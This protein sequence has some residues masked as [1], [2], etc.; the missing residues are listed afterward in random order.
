[1]MKLSTPQEIEVWYTLP[2]LRR[3]FVKVLIEEHELNQKEAAKKLGLTESAVSQ[4]LKQKRGKEVQF[5]EN[6]LGEIKESARRIINNQELAVPEL[7][8]VSRLIDV[9]RVICDIHRKETGGLE[10]CNVCFED[11]EN[12]VTIK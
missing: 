12:L 10:E 1:M 9:K 8:R 3:E 2:A 7:V 11:K 4:Y 6:I 5:G